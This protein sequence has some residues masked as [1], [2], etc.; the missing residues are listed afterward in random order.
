MENG[1]YRMQG[2]FFRLW[3]MYYLGYSQQQLVAVYKQLIR[4]HKL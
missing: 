1:I 3:A 4:K 2:I